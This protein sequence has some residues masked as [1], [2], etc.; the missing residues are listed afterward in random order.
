MDGNN[1]Y[2]PFQKHT[3]RWSLIPVAQPGVQ[4]CDLGSRQPPPLGFKRF[5]FLSLLSKTGFRHVGQAGLELVTS[6]DPPASA[7]SSASII[8]TESCS[9]AR[10]AYSGSISARCNLC[11]RGSR[12]SLTSASCV[13]GIQKTLREEEF[14]D[15]WSKFFASIGEREKCGSYLEKDFDTLKGVQW[16]CGLLLQCPLLRPLGEQTE[17]QVVGLRLH[18]SVQ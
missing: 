17:G 15:W 1:Q 16:G 10:L 11:L 4:W 6:G 3:K 7:S 18:S 8:D 2:Q 12:D 14:I 13:V 5:S 9:V